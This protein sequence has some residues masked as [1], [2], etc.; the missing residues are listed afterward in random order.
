MIPYIGIAAVGG[1]SNFILYFPLILH[2]FLEA[3]PLFK[4]KLD[5]SPNFPIISIGFIKNYIMN[6]VQ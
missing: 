1:G 6:G 2:G 4:E 3:S 5:R